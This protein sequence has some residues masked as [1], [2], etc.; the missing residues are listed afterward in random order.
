MDKLKDLSAQ[1]T[2]ALDKILP[3]DVRCAFILV[4]IEGK[5]VSTVS[6]MS[7]ENTIFL[8]EEAIEVLKN[9]ADTD[10]IDNLTIN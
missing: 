7:D 2:Q 3:S 1:V 4:D 5:E 9:P 8:L 10:N 6:D